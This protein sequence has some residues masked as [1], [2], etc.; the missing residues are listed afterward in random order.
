ME[1]STFQHELGKTQMDRRLCPEQMKENCD[2][3]QNIQLSKYIHMCLDSIMTST[4]GNMHL[5]SASMMGFEQTRIKPW[6]TEK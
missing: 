4:S 2:S 3:K 1:L 5:T 6:C